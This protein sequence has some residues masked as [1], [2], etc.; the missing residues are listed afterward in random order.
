MHPGQ[1]AEQVALKLRRRD[2]RR[3]AMVGGKQRDHLIEFGQIGLA[4]AA[5]DDDGRSFQ[6]KGAI[7]GHFFGPLVLSVPSGRL[8]TTKPPDG[9][10][11]TI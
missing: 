8:K 4:R 2:R 6:C 9:G 1:G 3:I 5:N 7:F 10:L 11:L